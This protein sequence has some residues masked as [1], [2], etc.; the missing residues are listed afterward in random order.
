MQKQIY[1]VIIIGAG[2]SGLMAA[3]TAARQGLQPL[4]LEHMEQ[5]A[6]KILATGNGKCNYTNADQSLENYYCEEPDF[7]KTVLAQFSCQDTIRFFEELGIRPLQKNG[8]CIYPESEQASSVKQ[9]LLAE[10]RRLHVPI[11][12][13]VGIRAVH[14]IRS[15]ELS[16]K[17]E[18]FETFQIETKDNRY[19]GRTCILATGGK[20]L[21]KTGSDGS[22]Y[23]Y[24]RQ[25]GHSIAAPLPALAAF[26]TDE[27]DLRL[28]AG[29]RIFCRASLYVDNKPTACESG[30]L[31][32]TDYGISGIV[33]FQFCR[34]ASRALE[35][36]RHVSVCL[37]FKPDMPIQ[38]L[39]AYLGKR[40]FSVYHR[41][42][43]LADAMTGFIPDRLT[44]VL[45]KRA[46]LQ[47]AEICENLTKKRLR[48]LAGLLK[49][50]EVTVTGTRGFDYA[51]VTTG[52]V[53]VQEIFAH[54][55]ESKIVPGLYFAGEIIDADAKCGGYNLQWAWSSGYVA[56][57]SISN[58]LRGRRRKQPVT[59]NGRKE[60]TNSYDSHS[61]D[62]SAA[63]THKNRY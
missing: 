12:F 25:L 17:S 20:S 3:V 13:S 46:G 60:Q 37:D 29:I 45:L 56:A 33:I 16:E 2:A 58:R 41:Q 52:G 32:I 30:E 38:Q 8:T 54:S 59:R 53:L 55:M 10:I 9:V 28:P 14:K 51:Q 5:A 42:Q 40:F 39:T 48:R 24:A 4:V 50:Y 63:W 43:Q 49:S 15:K 47:A 36:R 1:D 61:A 62:Q 57:N 19:T 21:K 22:G 35:Q 11:L 23:L 27:T 31:Q 44:G 7:I 26:I 34:V 6:K 18:T